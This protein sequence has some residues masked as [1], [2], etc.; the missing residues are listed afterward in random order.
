MIPQLPSKSA[1]AYWWLLT[2]RLAAYG[3]L[4]VDR[5]WESRRSWRDGYLCSIIASKAIGQ[6]SA[7]SLF[8]VLH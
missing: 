1:P 4:R 2:S 8:V 6:V 5:W 3:D 7:H